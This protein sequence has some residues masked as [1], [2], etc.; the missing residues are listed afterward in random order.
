MRLDKAARGT[1]GT[2]AP[3]AHRAMAGRIAERANHRKEDG[4]MTNELFDAPETTTNGLSGTAGGTGR[5]ASDS[6]GSGRSTTDTAKE[7]V[8]DVA[9]E[10]V[11]GGKHV[12]SVAT[13]QAKEVASEAGHQAKA[14]LDQARS[15]LMDHAASQQN[16]VAEQLQSLSHELG[17]MASA[18]QEEGLATDLAQQ[19]SRQVGT[20]AHWLSQREP[21]SLMGEMKDFARN[22]P[23]T[24]LAVAAGIGLVAGRMTRGVKAGP[25]V[26]GT[27]PGSPLASSPQEGVTA[28]AWAPPASPAAGVP[29]NTLNEHPAAGA[30]R[31]PGDAEL[32][33]SFPAQSNQMTP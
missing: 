6:P 23:G 9:H 29:A 13:D 8:Q 33:E 20:V 30:G 31:Y 11:H 10:G 21:G 18:S 26:E 4:P 28:P 15:E 16:R 2:S 22:K 7:Q 1:D 17:S 12:V 19:A 14:L 27:E 25:P 5:T 32:A 24:F 3:L